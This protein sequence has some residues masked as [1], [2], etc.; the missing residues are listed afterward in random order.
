MKHIK[1]LEGF[2]NESEISPKVYVRAGRMIPWVGPGTKKNIEKGKKNYPNMKNWLKAD[3]DSIIEATEQYKEWLDTTIPELKAIYQDNLYKM[4]M[5]SLDGEDATREPADHLG[6][7]IK[8]ME[9]RK[10]M[11]KNK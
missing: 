6:D 2:L 3:E 4:H 7:L 8:S 11:L 5:A 1:T 9:Y 10:K